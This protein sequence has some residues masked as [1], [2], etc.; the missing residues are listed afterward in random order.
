MGQ[1][2]F[3][4]FFIPTVFCFFSLFIY[5][6][7]LLSFRVKRACGEVK[8][9]WNG[10]TVFYHYTSL[11]STCI[12]N[13]S[14]I[15]SYSL[16]H[17]NIVLYP[18]LC[19]ACLPHFTFYFTLYYSWTHQSSHRWAS[20]FLSREWQFTPSGS[21]SLWSPLH[22]AA[23]IIPC[24]TFKRIPFALQFVQPGIITT[25]LNPLAPQPHIEA[26]LWVTPIPGLF[27]PL[28]GSILC[29]LCPVCFYS[30]K[31]AKRQMNPP[32]QPLGKLITYQEEHSCYVYVHACTLWACSVDYG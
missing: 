19:K 29:F 4:C 18:M 7:V 22:V 26:S 20:C 31:R 5:L 23:T 25:P 28:Q 15:S 11:D 30:G 6:F 14:F 32:T 16:F 17:E 9:Q 10:G 8:V 12:Y 1:I 13:N 3:R 24:A 2:K 21:H 27:C